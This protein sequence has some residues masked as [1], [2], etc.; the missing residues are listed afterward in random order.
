MFRSKEQANYAALIEKAITRPG[1]PLLAGAAAGLGK[2]HGFSIPLLQS[3]K[4]VAIAFS[5]RALIAQ[6]LGSAALQAAMQTA[7]QSSVAELLSRRE[8]VSTRDYQAHRRRVLQAQVLLITHAAALIDARSPAYADLRS[9]DVLLFDEA[10][11]LADAAQLRSTFQI[12]PHVLKECDA[13]DGQTTDPVSLRAVAELVKRKAAEPEDRAAAAAMLYALD[14]PRW[15][16]RVGWSEQGELVLVHAMPGRMLGPLLADAKRV[17]FTSG[18]LQVN[19][20]FDHFVRALGIK[21]IDPAS[22]HIDPAQHGSLDIFVADSALTRHAQAQRIAQ[23]PRPALVLTTSHVATKELAQLLPDAVAR[24][25]HEPLAQALA[26]CGQGGVLI[27]AGAWSGLDEPRLRWATVA[28]PDVPYG[29]PTQVSGQAVSH[30][31]DSVVCAVRRTNQGLHRGLRSPDAHCKLLLLDARFH[32]RELKAAIPS[33]FLAPDGALP[34]VNEGAAQQVTQR[35]RHVR[36][37]ALKLYGYQ[38][39]WPGCEVT[40]AHRLEAHHE[41]AIALGERHTRLADVKIYCANHHRDAHQAMR[42]AGS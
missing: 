6:Y 25:E 7:P 9:R 37:A 28:I 36:A 35:E 21:Q 3:G 12:S 31:I 39:M 1:S 27:A 20:S 11:L 23:A 40:Q 13:P 29:V 33:R 38:C 42:L 15:Y 22:R 5:T 2:T 41:V 8:F 16:K 18:T 17:I 26:R 34:S 19:G 32:R 10:D 4:R 30:Y 24:G 14:T